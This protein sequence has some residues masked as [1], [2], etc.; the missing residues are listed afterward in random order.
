MAEV[1][2]TSGASPSSS[3]SSAGG[4]EASGL[5][6]APWHPGAVVEGSMSRE[7]TVFF[8]RLKVHDV[9]EAMLKGISICGRSITGRRLTVVGQILTLGRALAK[10]LS[11][12]AGWGL[13]SSRCFGIGKVIV[14]VVRVVTVVDL[15]IYVVQAKEVNPAI[16][17]SAS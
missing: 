7:S 12:Q 3:E 9:A 17:H 1:A 4:E 2:S 6:L 11:V 5:L 13:L 16:G 15:I 14:S 8:L 10:L